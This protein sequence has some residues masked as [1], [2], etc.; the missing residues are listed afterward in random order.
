MSIALSLDQ[1]ELEW[2]LV[3]KGTGARVPGSGMVPTIKP[4]DLS[5]IARSSTW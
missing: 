1:P 3:S 2:G 4:D 5:L